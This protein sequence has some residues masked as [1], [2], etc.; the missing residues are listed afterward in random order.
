[1]RPLMRTL[2]E[3]ITVQ[4]LDD[5]EMRPQLAGAVAGDVESGAASMNAAPEHE[6]RE[7]PYERQLKAAR[8]VV[9]QD[10]KRV[11][12]LMRTWVGNDG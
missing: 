10:P 2:M 4:A 3:P 7:A 5:P 11:A 8:D 9:Q 12:Q 1:L 6:V